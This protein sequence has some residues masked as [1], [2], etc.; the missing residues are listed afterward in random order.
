M[1]KE[2]LIYFELNN[3]TPGKDYPATEP[4]LTWL[5]NYQFRNDDWL[6]ANHLSVVEQT[7]DLSANFCVT[8]AKSWINQN[9]PSLLEEYREFCVLPED[10]GVCYGRWDTLFLG[11]DEGYEYRGEI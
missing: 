1:K 8:A 9:C 7:L 6:A 2:D 11:Y 4:Y 3:W 5:A 10:E